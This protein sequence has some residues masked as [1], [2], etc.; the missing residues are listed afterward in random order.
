MNAKDVELCVVLM[1]FTSRL[2]KIVPNNGNCTRNGDG[3]SFAW[4]SP[5]PDAADHVDRIEQ[6]IEIISRVFLSTGENGCTRRHNRIPQHVSF[7]AANEKESGIEASTPTQN[8]KK[9]KNA[10]AKG[11]EYCLRDNN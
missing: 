2:H 5:Q 6:W 11:L 10:T 3:F 4:P 1:S 7:R 8:E 9:N